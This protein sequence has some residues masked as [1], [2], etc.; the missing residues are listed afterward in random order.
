MRKRSG[1]CERGGQTARQCWRQATGSHTSEWTVPRQTF[2]QPSIE[3]A[4]TLR[5]EQRRVFESLGWALP[6]ADWSRSKVSSAAFQLQAAWLT[7]WFSNPRHC[8]NDEGG[9]FDGGLR[10][11]GS[12]FSPPSSLLDSCT[13]V[14]LQRRSRWMQLRPVFT[15]PQ[16]IAAAG[17]GVAGGSKV[18]EPDVGTG[19]PSFQKAAAQRSASAAREARLLD[20]VVGPQSGSVR[21]SW[22]SH[23]D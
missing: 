3:R 13:T 12:F 14:D 4:L 7:S 2:R 6:P 18:P 22:A 5:F 21:A 20:A 17:P 23:R 11:F 15:Q 9:H 19:L 16:P 1:C 10:P 8:Q